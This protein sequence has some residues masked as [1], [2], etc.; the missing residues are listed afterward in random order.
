MSGLFIVS[1]QPQRFQEVEQIEKIAL[2]DNS[3]V[4][5]SPSNLSILLRSHPGQLLIF[6]RKRRIITSRLI[7]AR[8]VFRAGSK[9]SVRYVITEDAEILWDR[10]MA[11]R[12]Q[13]AQVAI[14]YP[15]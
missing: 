5:A 15:F 7:G 12:E 11:E 9:I 3:I 14:E 13:V 8:S 10:F 2:A 4:K 6:D 1:D